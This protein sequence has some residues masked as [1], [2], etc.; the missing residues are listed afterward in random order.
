MTKASFGL[1]HRTGQGE[2]NISQTLNE[3]SKSETLDS[4][5]G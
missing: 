2:K 3:T 5:S 1:D 4:M